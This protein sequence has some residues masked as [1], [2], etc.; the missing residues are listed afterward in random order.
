MDK[1]AK[2][3]ALVSEFTLIGDQ[4]REESV[5]YRFTQWTRG[6]SMC[7]SQAG[8]RAFLEGINTLTRQR[9]GRG[10]EASSEWTVRSLQ[11]PL[12]DTLICFAG[13]E[14]FPETTSFVA[15]VTGKETLSSL[16][17]VRTC[18]NKEV[19]KYFRALS[20]QRYD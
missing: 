18:K 3:D 4:E 2:W 20:P 8:L 9:F 17:V 15:F 1:D 11:K 16:D 10:K 14:G 6:Y 5:K 19:W 12:R 13:G 7:D